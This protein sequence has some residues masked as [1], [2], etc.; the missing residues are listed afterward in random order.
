MNPGEIIEFT[1]GDDHRIGTIVGEIGKK[2]LEVVTSDGDEMRATRDEV[3]F[4][5]G[6]SV[7]DYTTTS[8]AQSGARRFADKAAKFAGEVDLEMLWTFVSDMGEAMGPVDISELFFAST[9]PAAVLAITSVLREDFV[10]F[11]QKRGPMFEPRSDSQVEEL[12]KQRE[13]ELEK[14]R[15]RQTFV[16]G[17]VAVMQAEGDERVA[18]ADE[19]MA[20]PDF[21]KL[22]RV[23]Q[24]Y[25]IY[26]QDHDRADQAKELLGD[27]E[28]DLGRHLKGRYGEKAFRLMVDMTVWDE[29]ENLHLLRHNISPTYD[30]A[31]ANS[32]QSICE[33]SWEPESY[34]RDL[35][36]LLT[37]SIDAASTRDIDDALSVETLDGGGFRVGVHI[38][39]PSARVPAGCDVDLAARGRATSVYLPTGTFPMFPLSLSHDEMSL[40]EGELRPAVSS[41]LTFDENLELVDS[42]ISASMVE[43]DHRLTYDEVDRRLAGPSSA[44]D[45]TGPLADA[46]RALQKIAAASEK[47]RI[48]DGAVYI[49]LPELDL[50]VDYT[51]GGVPTI[52][53]SVLDSSSSSR[54][55][56]SELMI[57]NNQK[58]GEFC[59]DH[60]L[61]TLY[62]SQ[63][64]PEQELYTDDIMAIPE[65]LAREFAVVR[66][67]K[68]GDVTTQPAAHFGLGLPVY[69][70]SS[71]PIRRYS[72]LV[73]QRQVKA[74]LAEEEL[75]YGESDIME[76]LG[77]VESASRGAYLAERETTRYWTLYHLGTLKAETLEATVVEHKGHDE[78]LAAVLIHGVALKT[79]AKFRDRPPVGEVCNVEVEKADPRGDVLHVRQKALP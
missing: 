73:A 38:A 2:K 40:V 11:K 20:D 69:V 37:F 29:H 28:S 14:E 50:A 78:A 13:A 22:A 36:D 56:V 7:S 18:L 48:E 43:V 16:D 21:R 53:A 32:A 41:L 5:T 39:D 77:S 59:R 58:I 19:K 63:S 61:P 30:E 66:K 15:E 74:F 8:I 76:V 9:E 45:D 67:M 24:K 25:A 1:S 68:P 64:P 26:D 70:Q 33:Q 47:R 10:F 75:P 44:G 79:N 27:I 57:L 46:L 12:K 51:P 3:T 42:E 31:I 6:V 23:I 35:T 60:E 55:L 17:V 65:G 52:E 49:D 62:R 34:R 71:S 72:D 4:E 54:Q